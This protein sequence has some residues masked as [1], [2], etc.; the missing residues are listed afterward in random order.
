ML[1]LRLY[2]PKASDRRKHL[3][4]SSNKNLFHPRRLGYFYGSQNSK[5][6][7]GRP[8][9]DLYVKDRWHKAPPILKSQ[10]KGRRFAP[11]FLLGFVLECESCTD[12]ANGDRVTASSLHRIKNK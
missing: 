10:K 3:G 11:P 5:K 7:F 1:K 12:S 6:I 4:S 8:R 9:K 2:L